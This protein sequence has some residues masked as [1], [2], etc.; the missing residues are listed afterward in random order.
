MSTCQKGC[1][2]SIWMAHVCE[3]L[4]SHTLAVELGGTSP[5]SGACQLHHRS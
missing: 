5:A 3:C 1:G 4:A 2:R